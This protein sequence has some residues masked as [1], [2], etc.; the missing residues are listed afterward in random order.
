MRGGVNPVDVEN[1]VI[2]LSSEIDKGVGI[3]SA[4]QQEAKKANRDLDRAFATAYLKAAGPQTEKRYRAE[5][6]TAQL[7]ADA[8]I[9][10]VSFR[11]A[12]R[13]MK[14]LETQLSAWQTVAKSVTQMYGATGPGRG[15]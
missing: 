8:E 7:R 11:H 1:E 12:E 15:H 4:R 2:R 9:A 3:V 14:A 10:E 5:L 13:Q 6:E